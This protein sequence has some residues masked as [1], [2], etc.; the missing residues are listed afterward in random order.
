[1]NVP[2]LAP[3]TIS[4]SS[5]DRTANVA[6]RVELAGGIIGWGETPTLPAI[7]A[8][9]QAIALA[10]LEEI[11]GALVG[12]DAGEWRLIALELAE[13]LP[14]YPA[15]RAGLEMAVIDALVRSLGV[16]LFRFFGGCQRSVVTD[17][18]IPICPAD[19]A[20]KLAARYRRAGFKTLKTKIG[21]GISQD[22]ERLRAILRGYPRCR[23]VLDANAAYTAEQVLAML[24][25]LRG[26]G[27]EPCLLEQPVAREDWE[28]LGQVARDAGI[29]VAADESC[30]N[31]DDALRIARNGLAQVINV[32]LAKCGVVE[33]MTIAAIARAAGLELMIG[34]MVETRLA[35]GF[36]AHFAAGLGGFAWVD[37]DTP[38]LLAEDPVR[39]GYVAKGPRYELDVGTAGHGG[40]LDC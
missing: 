29:P 10:K 13:R 19:E 31:A 28:G 23:L 8:E 36:S 4:P 22:I 15:V 38:L 11:A 30:R 32:K 37:L 18:T 34:G 12:R 2:L 1:L 6:I 27:V 25:K 21:C 5:L 24:R 39:G 7:T 35:M 3:F 17:V 33:A 40:S 14:E 9:D 16:A 20:R 26:Y